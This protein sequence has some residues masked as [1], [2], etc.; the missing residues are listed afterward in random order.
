MLDKES[1]FIFI[2][3]FTNGLG[4]AWIIQDAIRDAD[5]S[6]DAQLSIGLAKQVTAISDQITDLNKQ[7]SITKLERDSAII[8]ASFF[9]GLLKGKKELYQDNLN[10]IVHFDRIT[11]ELKQAAQNIL[12]GCP[13]DQEVQK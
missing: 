3:I 2:L 7:L 12:R 1:L 8:S 9:A 11:D 10:Q 5:P 13:T 4:A 6:T